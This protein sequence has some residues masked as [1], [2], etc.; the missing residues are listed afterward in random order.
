MQNTKLHVL[1]HFPN[2]CIFTWRYM[3]AGLALE[4]L[5]CVSCL[6]AFSLTTLTL[7]LV[8]CTL[9]ANFLFCEV[10]GDIALLPFHTVVYIQNVSK[11]Q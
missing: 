5:A 6:A 9:P 10:I 7:L 2:I 1:K 4:M 8:N 3:R 11:T